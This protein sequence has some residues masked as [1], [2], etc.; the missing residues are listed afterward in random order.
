MRRLAAT[1]L[2]LFALAS[3]GARGQIYSLGNEP[4]SVKWKQI[5]TDNYRVVFPEGTDSLAKVYALRLEQYRSKVGATIGRLPNEAYRKPMPV[6]LHP[7]VASSNG[8]VSWAPRRMELYTVPNAYTPLPL[9]IEDHLVIH[10][11]RH[12]AQMQFG[13]EKPYRWLNVLCGEFWPGTMAALYPGHTFFEGDAVMAETELTRSGRGRTP[14]FLN[15][16]DICFAEGDFRDYWKWKQQSQRNYTPDDY[17]AGYFLLSG[18]R[19]AYDDPDFVSRYYDNIVTGWPFPFFVLQKTIRQASGKSL[20]ETFRDIAQRQRDTWAEEAAEREPFM[21]MSRL[22]APTRLYSSLTNL[23]DDGQSMFGVR[24]G[25]DRCSELVRIG[26]EGTVT[27]LRPFTS[28]SGRLCWSD[29]LQR[30]YWDEIITDER[31][32]MKSYSVIRY[33][34]SRGKIHNLTG[35]DAKYYNPCICGNMIAVLEYPDE[36]GSAVVILDASDGSPVSRIPAPDGM[37]VSDVCWNCGE[38]FIAAITSEGAGIYDSAFRTVLKPQFCSISHMFSRGGDLYFTSDRNGSNELHSL[39][40]GHLKQITSSRFGADHYRFIGDSLYCLSGSRD[41]IGLYATAISDLPVREVDP[42]CIFRSGVAEKLSAQVCTPDIPADSVTTGPVEK[43]S[44]G[45]HLLKFHSWLPAYES[46]DAIKSLSLEEI[47]TNLG[48]GA[49][50][51]FQNDLN[52]LQGSVGYSAWTPSSGWRNA[53]HGK[54]IYSG[55]LPVIEA[56]VDFNGSEAFLWD[57]R[58]PPSVA[59]AGYHKTSL[60]IP[61]L[62]GGLKMYIPFLFNSGGWLRG[63]IPTLDLTFSNDV[64]YTGTKAR[65]MG[66]L[67]ANV[68]GY[69]M[70]PVASSCIYPRFGVGAEIGCSTYPGLSSRINSLEYFQLYGYLPG[71]IRTHGIRLLA[72]LKH[73]GVSTSHVSASYAF[74][75]APVDWSFLGPVAFIR[76]FEFIGN[77]VWDHTFSSSGRDI[78]T[79]SGTVNARLGNLLWIPYDTRIGVIVSYTPGISQR[80]E[81]GL[82]FSIDM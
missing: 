25:L 77:C 38:L 63:V 52:T 66:T 82:S 28:K 58:T 76:N 48:L 17:R 59:K 2:F 78:I 71:I 40:D 68:R 64:F 61:S 15:Y 12:V 16:Y 32:E 41:G 67:S 80:P 55:L 47:S 60:G 50:V 51:L 56:S 62:T 72:L 23:T 27:P 5:R 46:F 37:Q 24:S 1:L 49:T 14:S 35:R 54:F 26:T 21:P 11:S 45:A 75:F 29:S 30:L 18:I 69:I 10:E 3:P 4:C 6:I 70:R 22:S 39:K 19:T 36:G 74:P 9:P 33:L 31:W 81:C 53:L 7:Y 34:D 20:N 42:D 73:Q 44:K 57:Y 8:M 43:Y 13:A 79:W 65:Y